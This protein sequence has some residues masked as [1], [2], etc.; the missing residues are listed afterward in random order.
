MKYSDFERS[1]AIISDDITIVL[2]AIAQHPLKF[3]QLPLIDGLVCQSTDGTDH[4]VTIQYLRATGYQISQGIKRA[5]DDV[6][7]V[8]GDTAQSV[9]FAESVN[10]RVAKRLADTSL[11][12]QSKT[13]SKRTSYASVNLTQ[14]RET[15]IGSEEETDRLV[16][17]P[18]S[19][20]SII[21]P[22]PPDNRGA[23]QSHKQQERLSDIFPDLPQARMSPNVQLPAGDDLPRV[24]TD[25]QP[26]RKHQA[27]KASTDQKL[28]MSPIRADRAT[29]ENT[30]DSQR[31]L[32]RPSAKD[33]GTPG[34]NDIDWDEDLRNDDSLSEVPAPKKPK[35]TST[36][37]KTSK[38]AATDKTFQVRSKGVSKNR[39]TTKS[40]AKVPSR[41]TAATTR[42]R[43][44]ATAKSSRYV[45]DS[46]AG[47]EGDGD[48]QPSSVVED[49][50]PMI[51]KQILPKKG[52]VHM[53]DSQ[54]QDSANGLN[55]HD[56]DSIKNVPT[57]ESITVSSRAAQK[58][59]SS[60]QEEVAHD[61][62]PMD[63][64][65]KSEASTRNYTSFGTK[66]AQT[67][68]AKAQ[69]AVVTIEQPS[70]KSFGNV[71][72][73]VE[74][75]NVTRNSSPQ[76]GS[77]KVPR[78]VPPEILKAA[79]TEISSGD[80]RPTDSTGKD[81][82][83]QVRTAKPSESPPE[84]GVHP[85]SP[86]DKN[87]QAG[88]LNTSHER[89]ETAR[90][91]EEYLE[92]ETSASIQEGDLEDAEPANVPEDDQ[93]EAAG[94]R[95]LKKHI[96]LAT[97]AVEQGAHQKGA[98][99]GIT[100]VEDTDKE[101]RVKK[102]NIQH[103]P[104][105]TE[106]SRAAIIASK[107]SP[108]DRRSR[109]VLQE[110]LQEAKADKSMD[111][112]RL[113]RR[114][115]HHGVRSS[116]S[117][118]SDENDSSFVMTDERIQR[119][120]PIVSFGARGP[121]NQGVVSP[122]KNSKI[123]D[124]AVT[125]SPEAGRHA[126]AKR[127]KKAVHS[128]PITLSHLAPRSDKVRGQ[129][130]AV[131]EDDEGILGQD[132]NVSESVAVGESSDVNGRDEGILVE[133][134]SAA[135]STPAARTT[136]RGIASQSSIVDENGSPRLHRSPG[137]LKSATNLQDASTVPE[138]SERSA[139]SSEELENSVYTE[140]YSSSPALFCSKQV[141]N[142]AA[143][144]AKA[145]M[146][147]TRASIGLQ[148]IVA[149]KF[150]AAPKSMN[151]AIF[152]NQAKSTLSKP[153]VL[154]EKTITVVEKAPNFPKPEKSTHPQ[155]VHFETD[156]VPLSA[157]SQELPSD[158]NTRV[159]RLVPRTLAEPSKPVEEASPTPPSFK[160]GFKNLLM[161]P[162]PLPPPRQGRLVSCVAPAKQGK[163]KSG[164]GTEDEDRTLIDEEASFEHETLTRPST[165]AQ[166]QQS[167]AS[168]T[169]SHSSPIP[170]H[171]R[172]NT[173]K[174]NENREASSPKGRITQQRLLDVLKRTSTVS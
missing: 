162:P 64:A 46:N 77:A 47:I 15:S 121:R 158:P 108:T 87:R 148:E 62:Y 146:I 86:A 31:R 73:F 89:R 12:L 120:T 169:D 147:P 23:Q 135:E 136:S 117:T 84:T 166:R 74:T 126:A 133:E 137:S 155:A 165:R 88:D 95:I 13:A 124:A 110:M 27:G 159:I 102:S 55:S 69:L 81:Q 172:P 157:S 35:T 149:A 30:N 59:K 83:A 56:L 105:K 153:P 122:S 17:V 65:T 154:V 161:P 164:S 111:L 54:S 156:H 144:P 127:R 7:L 70:R 129:S 141:S 106:L 93:E 134:E 94:R 51:S 63:I 97:V 36:N 16:H 75:V 118:A 19:R 100:P 21:S 3:L 18:E 8:F 67:L 103:E 34:K 6:H 38:K 160:T 44:E 130:S 170:E 92:Q 150:P 131:I 1:V 37:A 48:D 123:G 50:N 119:K 91:M 76:K 45:D 125:V 167:P 40:K 101:N 24:R 85:P 25:L 90:I 96:D 128:K 14:S 99:T 29:S 43:R 9:A 163:R 58:R 61:F 28:V 173:E 78:N 174:G 4:E 68:A 11:A 112:P 132:G 152:K 171:A 98:A 33:G 80:R 168:S 57:G 72:K 2:P 71:K 142:R 104:P 107:Q 114:S 49:S 116:I 151:T 52:E 22:S 66:I 5:T 109:K 82:L 42:T 79:V 143:Q 60:M 145:K 115:D 139:S 32:K 113:P 39:K 26:T 10:S 138:Q 140:H 53:N 41:N 20:A